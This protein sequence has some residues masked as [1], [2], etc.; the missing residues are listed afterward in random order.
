MDSKGCQ[1]KSKQKRCK[2]RHVSP[3]PASQVLSDTTN[4]LSLSSLNTYVLNHLLLFLDVPALEQLAK[5]SRFFEQLING[6]A[7]TNLDIPFS[8]ELLQEMHNASVIEKKPVLRMT[9]RESNIG[10]LFNGRLPNGKGFCSREFAI[11]LL[12]FQLSL[13]DLAKLRDLVIEPKVH[14]PG[15]IFSGSCHNTFIILGQK[16][17]QALARFG[18]LHRLTRLEAPVAVLKYYQSEVKTMMRSGDPTEFNQ[19]GMLELS[20]LNLFIEQKSDLQSL[21]TG[22]V[23]DRFLRYFEPT[24]LTITVL[25]HIQ[26]TK[27]KSVVVDLNYECVSLVKKLHIIG[28]CSLQ[29]RP[30][31]ESLKEVKVT[32][33]Q[34]ETSACTLPHVPEEDRMMHRQGTCCMDVRALW[35]KCPKVTKFN[36]IPLK[37]QGKLRRMGA[38]GRRWGIVFNSLGESF[39]KWISAS[40]KAFFKDYK[41]S[42][43]QLDLATWGR[44]YW[45]SRKLQ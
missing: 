21:D 40:K 9:V 23:V 4:R 36:S 26:F 17:I 39:P 38:R 45:N 20:S 6:Q 3:P 10:T 22:S 7:I 42:G 25:P 29:F 32:P 31:M 14:V 1:S 18:V 5:T 28:P 37:V 19:L 24:N 33:I 30:D 13:L 11:S 44:K 12:H 34:G 35:R 43:G 27:K 2:H 16:V 15:D 41:R 8:Q